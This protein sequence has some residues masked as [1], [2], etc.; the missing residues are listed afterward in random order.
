MGSGYFKKDCNEALNH[1]AKNEQTF[2]KG[3]LQSEFTTLPN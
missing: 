1:E 3:E 2:C